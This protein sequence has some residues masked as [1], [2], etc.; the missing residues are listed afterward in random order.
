MLDEVV[1]DLRARSNRPGID[2]ALVAPP[3]V[4][5]DEPLLPEPTEAEMVEQ[6]MTAAQLAATP[7]E[8]TSLLQTLLGLLERAAGYLPEAWASL[9]RVDAARALADEQGTDRAYAE[10]RTTT[11]AAAAR[12]VARADV[13]ALQRLGRAVRDAD[14]RLGRKRPAEVAALI[15]TL[16]ERLASARAFQLARDQWDLR[17]PGMRRYRRAVT[18]PLRAIRRHTP[19]LEDVRAQAGPSATSLTS[20]IERWRR[21]GV[22]LDRITPPAELVQ[23]HAL[24]QSAWQMA[25]QAFRLRLSAAA[26]NDGSRAEQASS[27][28]A[29][30]L[31]LMA[32][33]RADLDAALVRPAPNP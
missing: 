17:A 21:D 30:A 12:E 3:P 4:L 33:A 28:A 16:D 24:F 19:A 9:M 11:M 29:G 25:E 10:L 27:A 14:D 32:K 22:R 20:I 7:A 31:M 13:C 23:V 18:L 8:R 1:A 26:S 2:I 6:L 5:P 15:A